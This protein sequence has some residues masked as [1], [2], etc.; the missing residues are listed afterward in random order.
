MS[1]NVWRRVNEGAAGF[2]IFWVIVMAFMTST[3][4]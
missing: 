1:R 3:H 4:C 2:V